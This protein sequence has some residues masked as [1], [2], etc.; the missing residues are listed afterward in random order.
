[1]GTLCFSRMSATASVSGEE[2]GEKTPSTLS[3]V[4]SFS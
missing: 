1:M 2:Y 4:I 3:C